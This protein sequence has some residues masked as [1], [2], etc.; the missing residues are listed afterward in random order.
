MVKFF[1]R[2]PTIFVEKKL[3]TALEKTGKIEK[4]QRGFL[5]E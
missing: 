2:P 4:V 1:V 5:Q 3:T